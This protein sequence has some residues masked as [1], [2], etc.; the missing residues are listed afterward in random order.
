MVLLLCGLSF[1]DTWLAL[2]CVE[3][4]ERMQD[5]FDRLSFLVPRYIVSSLAFAFALRHPIQ[6]SRSLLPV[7]PTE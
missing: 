5:S 6:A 3:C 2:Q 4:G 1:S 7:V